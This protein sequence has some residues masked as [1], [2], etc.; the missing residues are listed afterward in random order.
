MQNSEKVGYE[1]CRRTAQS[2][3]SSCSPKKRTKFID[4][5]AHFKD[6]NAQFVVCIPGN[7]QNSA[8]LL[9]PTSPITAAKS[10]TKGVVAT[11]EVSAFIRTY[12]VSFPLSS[13]EI[14][15]S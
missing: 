9:V 13:T 6:L 12:E 2:V 7:Q 15:S 11:W 14:S 4:R 8:S 10:E 1:P 3:Y 5:L